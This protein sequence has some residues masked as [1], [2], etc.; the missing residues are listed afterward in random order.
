MYDPWSSEFEKE[1]DIINEQQD[2]PVDATEGQRWP[3]TCI[4]GK[5]SMETATAAVLME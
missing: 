3:K 4:T 2:E 5:A 1:P